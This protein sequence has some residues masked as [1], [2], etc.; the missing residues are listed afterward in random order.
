MQEK[1]ERRKDNIEE[2]SSEKKIRVARRDS[3]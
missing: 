3:S 1:D 2:R